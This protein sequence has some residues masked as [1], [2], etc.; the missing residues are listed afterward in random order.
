[1][2]FFLIIF[3]FIG[4][5]IVAA[6]ANRNREDS[7]SNSSADTP[8]GDNPE[9][10]N[11]ARELVK[12]LKRRSANVG[13]QYPTLEKSRVRKVQ[14]AYKP[15]TEISEFQK[16][17]NAI[18]AEI[19]QMQ[20]STKETLASLN[21]DVVDFPEAETSVASTTRVAFFS[22]KG[23]IRRAFIAS[24]ILSKPLSLRK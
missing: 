13:K 1:M 18:E 22:D 20:K 6:L 24:E 23:D 19:A 7:H 3:A 8:V 9:A 2:E 12:Q 16:R 15:S 10:F 17:K 14:K 11:E 21:V 4:C 5:N